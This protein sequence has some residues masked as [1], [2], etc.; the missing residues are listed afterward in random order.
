MTPPDLQA[1]LISQISEMPPLDVLFNGFCK[2]LVKQGLPIWRSNIGLET[3]HPEEIGF[4][5]LWIDGEL[6]DRGFNRLR[7]G[8]LASS[9]Y[10]NSPAKYVDDTNRPFRWR[11]GEADQG[12]GILL[13]MVAEGVTEYTMM[14]LVFQDTYRSASISFATKAPG[15]FGDSG[16]EALRYATILISP[17]A[18]RI[19]LRRVALDA[20]TVYLGATAAQRA[21]S[22][23][24]E[25]GDV[26]TLQAA[27]LIADLRGFTLLSDR[28]ERRAMVALLDRWFGVMGEAIEANGGDILKFMGDGLLAVFPLDDDPSGSCAHALAAAQQSIM[29]T[30]KLNEDLAAEGAPPL[31]FGM[32]LHCGEV[33]FG[34]IGAKRRI[35]FTV[36]GPAVNHASRLESLTKVVQQPLVLSDSFART[37][38]KP[39]R[40]LGSHVLRGV[41]EPVEVFVP[42]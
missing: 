37:L 17:L 10:L 6:K 40:S 5:L 16:Y 32:A 19:A 34:N 11:Q 29:G 12:M 36:I 2:K 25:R 9:D 28:L 22:G 38:G 30:A 31:K 33:E 27:I 4:S 8:L 15:G 26:R 14:P 42:Q 39:L 23:Q 13:D 21:Y 3:L 18:E 24:I 20:L 1:W 35:D 41:R 7:P